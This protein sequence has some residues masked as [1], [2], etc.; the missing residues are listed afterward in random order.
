M[1]N[2]LILFSYDTE[3]CMLDLSSDRKFLLETLQHQ[4]SPLI[5][6][7][8]SLISFSLVPSLIFSSLL[9]RVSS[10]SSSQLSSLSS[11]PTWSPSSR[12]SVNYLSPDIPTSPSALTPVR[13]TGQ[14]YDHTPQRDMRIWS[15]SREWPP[16]PPSQ[17]WGWLRHEPQTTL[18]VYRGPGYTRHWHNICSVQ[19]KRFKTKQLS[20]LVGC[21]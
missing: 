14:C 7:S 18:H 2:I 9:E 6:L 15:G 8:M 21:I 11:S 16:N 4:P 10:V 12:L 20:Y 5:Y 1:S 3:A 13:Q 17:V 19:K